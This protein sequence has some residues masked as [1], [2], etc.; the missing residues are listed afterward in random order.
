MVKTDTQREIEKHEI[1][2]TLEGQRAVLLSRLE[3]KQSKAKS[4]DV[5]NADRADLAQDY[6]A[7]DR[8]TAMMEQMRE[9]LEHIEDALARLDEGLYGKC[10]RCGEEISASRLEALPY[11]QL[12][13]DCKKT[14]ESLK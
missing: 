8:H 3:V 12:C 6:F 2:Q 11:A 5:E 7:Q 4:N 14:V 9:T 1:R 13:I 10:T